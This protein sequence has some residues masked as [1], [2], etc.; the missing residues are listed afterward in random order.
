MDAFY[1]TRCM[2][3]DLQ[4]ALT[5][6]TTVVSRPTADRAVVGAGRK[7]LSSDLAL[8]FV[9]GRDDIRV[10]GLSAEHG[11]LELSESARSLKIGDRLELVPGYADTSVVL[12]DE[13]YGF[14]DGRLEVVWPIEARGKLR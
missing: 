3:P 5:L 10:V 9:A 14:R 7:S 1:R 12:H 8:P 6:L 4:Y 11:I 2:V 13:L